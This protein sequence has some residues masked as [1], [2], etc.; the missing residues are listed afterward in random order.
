MRRRHHNLRD[1]IVQGTGL[2]SVQ[3]MRYDARQS[4]YGLLLSQITGGTENNDSGVVLQLDGARIG[5]RI[6]IWRIL[7]H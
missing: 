1:R 6:S 5:Q 7:E 2:M 4:T 3:Q